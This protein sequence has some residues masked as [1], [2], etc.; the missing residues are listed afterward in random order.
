MY[1]KITLE[2]PHLLKMEGKLGYFVRSSYEHKDF[3]MLLHNQAVAHMKTKIQ[4]WTRDEM[5]DILCAF[6]EQLYFCYTLTNSML[7]HRLPFRCLQNTEQGKLKPK[8][9]CP[10]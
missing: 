1:T 2:Y 8:L 7:H 10:W 6:T 3:D 9:Y 4:S 5:Y